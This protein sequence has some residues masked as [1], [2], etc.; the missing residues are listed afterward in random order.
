MDVRDDEGRTPLHEAV[1]GMARENDQ[2]TDVLEALLAAGADP[3]ARD[4][5]GRTPMRH[6]LLGGQL[7]V[8]K[9]LLEAGADP[10]TTDEW[11]RAAM[12]AAI[13]GGNPASHLVVLETGADVNARGN[14]GNTPLHSVVASDVRVGPEKL[15]ERLKPESV[16]MEAVEVLIK[17]GSN[18]EA[19]NNEGNTP[20]HLAAKYIHEVDGVVWGLMISPAGSISTMRSMAQRLSLSMR[21]MQ[22]GSCWR[23]GQ[24]AGHRMGRPRPRAMFIHVICFSGGRR[25]PCASEEG[26]LVGAVAGASD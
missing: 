4:K 8:Y 22:S 18:L 19:R 6:A 26:F 21:A 20:L 24:T 17:A 11:G 23:P 13:F 2:R 9:V 5:R 25:S 14:E 12:H 16:N 3:A 15:P 1:A 7:T 10:I